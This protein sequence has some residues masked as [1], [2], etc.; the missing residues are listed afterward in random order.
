M[1]KHRRDGP[2]PNLALRSHQ[3]R[4]W[5]GSL[6]PG[7]ASA[8]RSKLR[9]RRCSKLHRIVSKRGKPRFD[10]GAS[11]LRGCVRRKTIA[12]AGPLPAGSHGRS[13][14]RP[15]LPSPLD[16]RDSLAEIPVPLR[17]ALPCPVSRTRSASLRTASAPVLR[18][19]DGDRSPPRPPLPAH[20]PKRA[21]RGPFRPANIS[22]LSV[23]M[24]RSSPEPCTGQL[25]FAASLDAAP[26][27][28]AFRFSIFP[29]ACALRK[30]RVFLRSL[31]FVES[32]A[33][34]G[35]G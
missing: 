16:G 1:P 8:Q 13:F 12:T 26:E 15:P 29:R 23:R 27:G 17:R 9:R 14:L 5:R 19:E 24:N 28:A 4:S 6:C 2:P 30:P 33:C 18:F 20:A 7:A 31:R 25:A 21:S 11:P 3:N 10:R 32:H 35:P 34:G 22:D